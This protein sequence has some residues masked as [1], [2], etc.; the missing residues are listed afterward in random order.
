MKKKGRFIVVV[1]DSFGVGAMDDVLEVRPQD[2]GSNTCLHLIESPYEKK[3][4]TLCELGLMNT[5]RTNPK[6]MRVNESATWGTS[7]LKHFGA[8]SY[9]GHQEIVGTKPIMPVF[10]KIQ[11]HLD[12]IETDLLSKGYKVERIT[13]RSLQML[14]VNNLIFIGDNMETDLGQA[15]NVIGDLDNAGFELIKTIGMIVR[16]HVKV[17][18]VIAY[19]GDNVHTDKLR[20]HI[21]TVD[22]EFIGIDAPSTGV[23][24]KNYTV[25]HIGYGV[26]FEK[27]LPYALS[28]KDIK[29]Y[30]Y[31]KTADIINN[32]NGKSFPCIDTE[33]T[34]NELLKDMDC[35]DQGFMFLNIQETDLAGHAEDLER[36]VDRLNVSD[37]KIKGIMEKMN[38]EDIMIVM[39]DHGNDPTI[40]HSKHTRERV[41]LLIT[42][43]QIKNG[44]SI[45]NRETMADVGQTVADYFET[46]LDYGTSFLYEIIK[47]VHL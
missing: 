33:D 27:Q 3:W 18:R 20:N 42:G 2:D 26:D 39:A 30:F 43:T 7:N 38:E 23:Y 21:I 47:N 16:K 40:G 37:L 14:C 34:F 5:L 11:L 8:D 31:G 32:P 44:Q 25:I 4:D 19:G 22:D 41:P 24:E 13:K 15:I 1:L 12:D 46:K 36:Y 29:N 35:I 28:Q 9:N 45:G 17:S 6:V 10:S